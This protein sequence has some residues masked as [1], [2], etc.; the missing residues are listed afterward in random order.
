MLI[1]RYGTGS[2]ASKQRSESTSSVS[3]RQRADS[4]LLAARNIKLAFCCVA[5]VSN[6]VVTC[7][8]RTN[9][10]LILAATATDETDILVKAMAEK[11]PAAG[12]QQVRCVSVDNPSAKLWKGLRCICPNLQILCL[13]PV[14]LAM[15]CDYA[16]SRKRTAMSRTLR[17][18][19][20]K[21]SVHSSRC[22][23]STWGT[24]FKGDNCKPLTHE[25]EKA[26]VQIEDRSMPH[27]KA[28][29]ILDNLDA[30]VPFFER[31]EWSQSLATLAA[32]YRQD[33][34][35]VVPGPNRKVYELLHSAAAAARTEWYFN[36]LR[37]RHMIATSRLSL[38]PVGTTSNESL[39]HEINNFF[40][41]TQKIQKTTL[42]LKLKILQLSKQ[43]THN[44]ALYH[45]TTRQMAEAE[46]LA[47]TS[48]R[49]MWSSGQWHAWCDELQD[50][51][52][53]KKTSLHLHPQREDKRAI[54]RAG[55]QKRPAVNVTDTPPKR[56]RTPHTLDRQD[57]LRRAGVRGRTPAT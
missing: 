23:D 29:A 54:V 57:S 22:T 16:S 2:S 10:V 52:R 51:A 20:Q 26:R 32:V 36:N 21:L 4:G 35:R 28:T 9:A 43:M 27:R 3:W 37:A 1:A 34:D 45:E 25:E 47:R 42:S 33:M 30:S 46:V 11:L 15:T 41:E 14:H 38:L 31:S 56:R 18:I 48:S 49:E 55:V 39:H 44:A 50:D 40:R 5:P 12:L 8:G 6:E 53:I 19:L 7:R 24:I 13:D 17:A